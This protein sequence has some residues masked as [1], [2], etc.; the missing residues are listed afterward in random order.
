MK[1]SGDIRR[2]HANATNKRDQKLEIVMHYE[3]QM[4]LDS[5][6]GPD[7]PEWMKAQSR[8]TNRLF[9]KAVDDVERLVIMRLLELTKLQ[10]SGLG[11]ALHYDFAFLTL[12]FVGYK[13]RTQISKALKS[14]ANAI[15]NT[16][17]RYNKYGALL[18]P[19]HPPLQWD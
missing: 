8:I 15:R 4:A 11:R 3:H 2:R 10:M 6:W 12:V 5:R 18:S 17:T 9:H 16:L 1:E 14:R 13:L 7:H 19:P